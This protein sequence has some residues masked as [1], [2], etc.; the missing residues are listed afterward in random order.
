MPDLLAL[1][2]SMLGTIVGMDIFLLAIRKE[3]R[4]D[5]PILA[6]AVIALCLFSLGMSL[7][8]S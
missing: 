3:G 1:I 5:V 8:S 7:L 6:I 4:H 2:V